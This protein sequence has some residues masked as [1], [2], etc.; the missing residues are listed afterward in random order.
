MYELIKELTEMSGP[1]GQEHAVVDRMEALWQA[2]GARTERTGINNLLAHVGGKGPRLLLAAHADELSYL[3]RAI[4]AEGFLWLANGQGWNRTTSMRNAF[5]IGQRVRVLADSG[6]LPGIIATTTGHLA[7]QALPEPAELD[8]DDFWVDTGLS[9]DELLAAG[10][11]PGT[12]VIWHAETTRFG[13]H[14]VGKAL[15]DRVLLAVLTELQSRLDVEKLQYELI[16]GCT[17]Q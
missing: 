10:V 17:V 11:R 9:R 3:V 13:A 7:S 8:W 14:V 12:R 1:I 16:L 5:T 4:D 15:D 6:E 2:G